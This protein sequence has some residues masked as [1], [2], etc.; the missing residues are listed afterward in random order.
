ML[1]LLILAAGE[2]SRIRFPKALLKIG[3]ETFVECI[4]RKA[5]EAGI[6]SISVI[7]GADHEK[8]TQSL[9]QLSCIHNENYM[10]GQI[11]S[12]QKGISKLPEMINEVMVWPVDQPLI[13][14][15]TVASLIESRNHAGRALTIPVYQDRKGHPVIY[16]KDAME[17][18]IGL[19]PHQT[20]KDLQ[21]FFATNIS[22]VEVD[23][24]GVVID[25]DTLEDYEKYIK[26]S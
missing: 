11:S 24:P 6:G 26:P 7:T 2:S 19:Q 3:E 23:D 22:F 4:I 13:K 17:A 14:R 10:Q 8:I 18:A 5:K 12:L 15:E 1:A 25:I 21:A 16:N 20:G 9:S